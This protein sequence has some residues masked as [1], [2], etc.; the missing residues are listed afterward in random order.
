MTSEPLYVIADWNETFE[1]HETRKLKWLHWVPVPTRMDSDEYTELLDH[2]DGAAH[3]GAWIAI[4]KL[5]S[6]CQPRGKLIRQ[7]PGTSGKSPGVPGKSPG[8]SEGGGRPHTAASISRI[9][10]IPV[11]V[12]KA[13]IPRLLAVGWLKMEVVD[14]AGVTENL[15]KSPDASGKS[16]GTPGKSPADLKGPDLNRPEKTCHEI[17]MSDEKSP[18]V[19]VQSMPGDYSDKFQEAWEAYPARPHNPKKA[20]WKAWK[21]RLNEGLTEDTLL[22]ATR[23]YAEWIRREGTEPR[24]VKMA[25]T[26]YGP[27]GTWMSLSQA[28]R[29]NQYPC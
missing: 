26:F 14:T 7:S 24:F 5:A 21:A 18:D 1:T 27:G 8:T 4:V 12:I 10:R 22:A 16:P 3:F 13:A 15:P 17:N 6:A 2:P 25:A 28:S 19:R 11:D 29:Q 20:A 23:N 9:T